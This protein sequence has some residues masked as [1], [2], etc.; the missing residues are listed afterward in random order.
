[1]G[2]GDEALKIQVTY[3]RDHSGRE[4]GQGFEPRQQMAKVSTHSV[5]ISVPVLAVL[6]FS[7]LPTTMQVAGMEQVLCYIYLRLVA[8]IDPIPILP[9]P[10]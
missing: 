8:H 4:I 9:G 2:E 10:G 5:A 1:M 7:L 3:P 6:Y